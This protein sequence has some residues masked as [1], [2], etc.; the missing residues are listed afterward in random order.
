MSCIIFPLDTPGLEHE[1][2]LVPEAS[3]SVCTQGFRRLGDFWNCMH[4]IIYSCICRFF[5]MDIIRF[6][7]VFV[8]PN[9]DSHHWF[10]VFHGRIWE[11]KV[12]FKNAKC[13]ILPYFWNPQRRSLRFMGLS[14]DWDY[15]LDESSGWVPLPFYL[16]GTH[17]L[18]SKKILPFNAFEVITCENLKVIVFVHRH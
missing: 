10:G 4:H 3:P 11:L 5:W 8:I 18:A 9:K 16:S 6:L 13:K 15:D 12:E 1:F 7:S 17:L 2:L 14:W